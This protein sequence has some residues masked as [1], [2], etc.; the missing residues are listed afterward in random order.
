MHKQL[1]EFRRGY[2]GDKEAT[3]H[4]FSD[5]WLRTGD[6]LKVDEHQNFWVTDRLKEVCL[7]PIMLRTRD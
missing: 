4:T 7:F 6:I 5:G 1:T 2:V 3:E